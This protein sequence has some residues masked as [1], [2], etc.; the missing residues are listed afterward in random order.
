MN[1][2]FPSPIN[3][4]EDLDKFE[5]YLTDGTGA[6]L[7]IRYANKPIK[8]ADYNNE[9]RSPCCSGS[10]DCSGFTHA[11]YRT[12]QPQT[13]PPTQPRPSFLFEYLTNKIG[14]TVRVHFLICNKL[15]CKTGI[16]MAVEPNCIVLR[17][18]PGCQTW[19]CKTGSVK[20]VTILNDHN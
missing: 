20:F 2:P 5:A 7:Q 19:M 16:L 18:H 3:N 14:K 6:N 11:D 8:T 1:Y 15:E 10:S 17:I 12:E 13:I 9:N 4:D